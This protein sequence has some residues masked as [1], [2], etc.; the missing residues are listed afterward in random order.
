MKIGNINVFS[1][2][3]NNF[4]KKNIK[5]NKN[6]FLIPFGK[7]VIWN[8]GNIQLKANLLVNSSLGTDNKTGRSSIIR[9]DPNGSLI[10]NQRFNMYY[11]TDVTVFPKGEL[12][13]NG[14]FFNSDVTVR[15]KNRISIGKGVAISHGVLIQDYDG[16]DLFFTSD[17]G[18]LYCP[19]NSAPITICDNVLVFANSSILKG[20]TIGEG[21]IVACGSV[22]TEDVPEHTLVAGVPAKVIKTGVDWKL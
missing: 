4:F 15:C 21:A 1:F 22:V 14:G 10:V 19:E 18:K 13:L 12:I 2:I 3:K 20:V 7:N 5:R 9:I 6:A 16:H 8:K 11:G 17:D